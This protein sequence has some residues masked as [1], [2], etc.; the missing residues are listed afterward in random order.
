MMVSASQNLAAVL[1]DPGRGKQRDFFT[2]IWG[3][4]FVET[5]LANITPNPNLP[6]ITR[7]HFETYL[8]KISK[9]QRSVHRA[10][11]A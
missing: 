1:N 6:L 7:A 5:P 4:D 9:V 3:V 8:R 2:K 10:Q 11:L